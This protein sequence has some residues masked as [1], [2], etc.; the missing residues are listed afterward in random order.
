[1]HDVSRF[2]LLALCLAPLACGS[3]DSRSL[4]LT[5][6]DGSG[7]KGTVELRDFSGKGL[8]FVQVQGWAETDPYDQNNGL[9]VH[10]GRCAE[11]GELL[12]PGGNIGYTH[13]QGNPSGTGRETLFDGAVADFEGQLAFVVREYR[14]A[15]SKALAC[16]DL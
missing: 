12:V 1:M 14:K 10:R 5:A 6:L 3:G 8:F 15:N 7:L 2:V 4:P 11:P 16:A 13:P 9:F